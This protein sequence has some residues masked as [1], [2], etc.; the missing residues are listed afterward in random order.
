[1]TCPGDKLSDKLCGNY[2]YV[3][4]GSDARVWAE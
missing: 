1:M 4:L 2:L 3:L